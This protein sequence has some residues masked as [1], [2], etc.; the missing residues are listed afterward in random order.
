[1]RALAES[2]DDVLAFDISPTRKKLPCPYFMGDI[3]DYLA[4]DRA[5]SEHRTEAAIHLA[6]QT[7]VAA[8]IDKPD[9]TIRSNVLGTFNIAHRTMKSNAKLL[10]ASSREV[11]GEKPGFPTV[12]SASLAPVNVYGLSKM[13][14]EETIRWFASSGGLRYCILRLTNVYG[15][16]GDSYVVQKLVRR[17]LS[18]DTIEIMGG[19][20][21]MNFV[22]VTDVVEAFKIALRSKSS[23]NQIFNVGS[24]ETVTVRELVNSILELSKRNIKVI[25]GPPPPSIVFNF[26]PDIS[27]V[28]HLLG[29]TPRIS[30][31]DGIRGLIDSLVIAHS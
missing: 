29:W 19:N 16:G 20:Q 17:A 26:S 15:P 18:G 21:L 14:A 11:Y 28:Q 30:L 3:T 1:V 13:L 27:L 10:F 31:K 23:E 12:E 6:G 25:E 2:G 7:G 4:V 24:G 5:F 22:H 8:S 9:D